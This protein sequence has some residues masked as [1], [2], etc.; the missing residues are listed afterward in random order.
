M[1]EHSPAS[2]GGLSSNMSRAVSELKKL[3]E[4]W[5]VYYEHPVPDSKYSQPL[6]N[7]LLKSCLFGPC[8]LKTF[9]FAGILCGNPLS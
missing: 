2:L 7:T 8:F 9:S 3:S 6:K 1:V 5:H 4:R